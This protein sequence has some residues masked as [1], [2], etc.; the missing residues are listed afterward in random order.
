MTGY[1]TGRGAIALALPDVQEVLAREGATPQPG[2][3][4]HVTGAADANPLC[5]LRPGRRP[6][7]CLEAFLRK[8][9]DDYGRAIRQANIKT[10]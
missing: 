7:H 6:S 3:P 5:L 2:T 10:Q 8:Q 4:E 1:G 9:Y